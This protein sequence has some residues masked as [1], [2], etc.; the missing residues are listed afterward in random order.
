MDRKE[1]HAEWHDR[2]A[3]TAANLLARM[4]P[5][6]GLCFED[7]KLQQNL[8]WPG[9]SLHEVALAA[10]N[11]G[12][13]Y[14]NFSARAFDKDADFQFHLG[15]SGA[16]FIVHGEGWNAYTGPSPSPLPTQTANGLGSS[17][18]VVLAAASPLRPMP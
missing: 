8:P 12:N 18:A 13:P 3:L 10:M 11:G 4:S 5:V 7:V 6:V 16:D 9:S 15:R 14:G 2:T 17:L 1:W